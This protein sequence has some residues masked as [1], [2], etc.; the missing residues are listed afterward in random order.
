MRKI[1]TGLCIIF[2][3]SATTITY[4]EVV[5]MKEFGHCAVG[6]EIDDVTNVK[7]PRLICLGKGDKLGNSAVI[8]TCTQKVFATLLQAG[9]QSHAD[10][11]ID[12]TYRFDE[13]KL[14]TESW[15]YTENRAVNLVEGV[16][17]RF[18]ES[19]AK[20][21]KLV[22][23]VG[24]GPGSVDLTG[25]ADAATEYKKRCAALSRPIK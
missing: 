13:G 7:S 18:V 3:L 23:E 9:I 15:N 5:D 16:H 17:H 21:K 12:V 1:L 8:L 4:S 19:I 25:S 22:F 24:K 10:E 6:T 14:A 11:T 20:A 2:A